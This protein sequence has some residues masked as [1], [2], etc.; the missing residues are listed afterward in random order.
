VLSGDRRRELAMFLK[1]R[2]A[3]RQPEE[4]GLPR[5]GRRRTP[6]LRRGEVAAVAGVSTEWYTWLE[7]ARDV[8]PSADVLRRIAT[9]LRLEPGEMQH[10][11]TLAG[12]GMQQGVNGSHHLATVHPPLQRLIEQLGACPAWILGERWD[13]LGW[14][15]AA[16]VIFGDLSAMQGIERN[17]LYQVFLAPRFRR[18]LVDWSVHARDCVAKIR[19]AH[20]RNLDDAWFIELIHVLRARSPEFAEWWETHDVQLPGNGVKHYDH[21][22]VGRL[23]FDFTVLDLAEA[24]PASVQLVTYVPK[25]GTG[26]QEKMEMLLGSNTL[27]GPSGLQ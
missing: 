4:I 5:I 13:I 20:A 10:L 17:I 14:N 22:E 16:T 6:G 25:P 18:M 19:V 1:A 7:Q 2:R 3:R 27:S 9:A 11:F 15:R 8:R 24:R 26:T 12:Y 23:S 21:P